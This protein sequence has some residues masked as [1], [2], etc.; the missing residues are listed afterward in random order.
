MKLPLQLAKS[1]TMPEV[2][3]WTSAEWRQHVIEPKLDG[4]RLVYTNGVF[5]S[6]T[7]KP[8]HHLEHLTKQ[9]AGCPYMLDGELVSDSWANTMS[10]S[11]ASKSQRDGSQLRFVIFDWMPL[12]DW[13][14]RTYKEPW[15]FRRE[16]S[17]RILRDWLKRGVVELN[18]YHTVDNSR[19]FH[20]L[21]KGFLREGCDGAMIK[22]R[23]GQ[24]A[25]KRSKS[26]LKVKPRD[27]YDA[28]ITGAVGGKGK[29]VGLLGALKAEYKGVEFKC[30]GMTDE[31]RVLF[32]RELTKIV[33]EQFEFACRGFHAKTGAPIEPRFLR[34]R[35]DL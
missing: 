28:F 29:Y 27:T 19:E 33:G 32:W 2:M 9:L 3:K 20:A 26:W 34:M 18:P 24:Y 15:Q 25:F 1:I 6:R 23:L 22:H 8:F 11:R 7:G 31:Q 12:L 21:Y 13:D 14:L 5:T 16:Y 30:S 17:F 4:A 10:I 35:Y